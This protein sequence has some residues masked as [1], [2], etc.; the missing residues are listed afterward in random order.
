MAIKLSSNEQII[1]EYSYAYSTEGL[2]NKVT[3]KN[4]LIVTNKRIIKR[5]VC[6]KVGHEK[7]NTSEI[8]V[9]SITGIST[10]MSSSFKL[11]YLVL[12]II[13]GLIGLI[14]LIGAGSGDEDAVGGAIFAA[15]LF[16]ALAALC[17]YLFIKTR[18][19][20]LICSFIIADRTTPAMFLGKATVGGLFSRFTSV[21]QSGYIRI[22]VDADVAKEFVNEIGALISD[23]QEVSAN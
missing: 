4:S 16:I 8:P 5:D 18:A 9:K 23:I 7:I 6:D 15:L 21:A 19:N 10:S 2:I 1:K 3:T 12:G 11:I 14:S 13:F 22:V 17:I 20:M